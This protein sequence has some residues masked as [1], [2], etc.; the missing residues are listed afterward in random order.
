MNNQYR[1]EGQFYMSTCL[2]YSPQLFNQT[3]LVVALKVCV[4]MISIYNQLT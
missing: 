4:D 3:L 2:G 1:C